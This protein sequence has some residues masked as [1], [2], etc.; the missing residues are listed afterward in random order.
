LKDEDSFYEMIREC[1]SRDSRYFA[2]FEHVRCECLSAQSIE[3]FICLIDESFDFLNFAIWKSLSRR[4]SLSV[5]IDFPRERL[6][7]IFCQY[8][9]TD[10]E[11]LDGIIACLTRKHCGHIMDRDVISIT[12][13]GVGDSQSHPLRNLADFENQTDFYTE[14]N[15]NS[16]ICYD[17]KNMRINLTSYS[18]RTRR[19]CNG[20]HLRSWILE[21]SIDC[22]SWIELDRHE[23]DSSLNGQGAIATFKI[24]S[25]S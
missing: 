12:A 24:S 2:L 22:K 3:S 10:S 17:F 8:S 20:Y 4:L 14:V 16:W 21:G 23:N 5:S 9:K 1:F 11:S 25:D 6:A 15:P 7:H 13:S 18:I 19:D